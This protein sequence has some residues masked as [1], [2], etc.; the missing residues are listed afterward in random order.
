MHLGSA[1]TVAVFPAGMVYL[2]IPPQ[3]MESVMRMRRVPRRE[4]EAML[5]DL[6]AMEAAARELL[7]EKQ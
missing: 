7:N 5:L 1:W 2:G 3:S 6:Q 4:Q